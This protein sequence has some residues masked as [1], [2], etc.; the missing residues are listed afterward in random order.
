MIAE[1]ENTLLST[2]KAF[3]EAE[4]DR[5]FSKII[6]ELEKSKVSF[7]KKILKKIL[8]FRKFFS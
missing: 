4:K 7:I 5:H 2:K 1:K 3:V 8:N 6:A